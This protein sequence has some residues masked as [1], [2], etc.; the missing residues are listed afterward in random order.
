MQPIVSILMPAYNSSATIRASIVSCLSQTFKDFELIILNSGSNEHTKEIV[1]SFNDNRIVYL[2]IA[3][4]KGIAA[5]RNILLKA[6][7]GQFI[8]W[9]DA[10]DQMQAERLQK[11]VDYLKLHPEIDILGSWI[12]TDSDEVPIKKL[13]LYHDMIKH[14]LWFKNCMIQ[15][16][17]LSRNFYVEESVY[18]DENYANSVEDYELWYRLRNVKKFGNIAETLTHYHMTTG[19]DLEHKRRVNGFENNLL[20][21]W[22]IK[23]QFYNIKASDEQKSLFVEFLYENKS[24]NE[25]D[26][27]NLLHIL[28]QLKLVEKDTCFDLLI[29]YHKL[30]LWRNMNPASK[31][32]HLNLLLH[33]RAWPKLKHFYLV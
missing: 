14:G 21:L 19:D 17:I 18:Y 13:P 24:L 27:Y 33:L 3:E 32:K 16:A 31:I 8:A 30:R 12:T 25:K 26:I 29:S 1:Q 28:N 10:D 6:S 11:Q 20:K 23:W 22:S 2:E 15:P 5:S 7:K 4:N 9:L